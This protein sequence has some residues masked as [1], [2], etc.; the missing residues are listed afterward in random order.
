VVHAA[1]GEAFE[2]ERFS[3]EWAKAVYL[4]GVHALFLGVPTGIVA[5]IIRH[6]LAPRR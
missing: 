5:A 4:I 1:R 6:V 2:T 3:A